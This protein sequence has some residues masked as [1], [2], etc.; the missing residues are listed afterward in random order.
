MTT[1]KELTSTPQTRLEALE[2]P[3]E[4]KVAR[5]DLDADHA[6]VLC[7]DFL[8]N[9]QDKP[10]GQIGCYLIDGKNI[11]S[12]LG[13][14]VETTVLHEY[15]SN[16]PELM[17]REYGPYDNASSFLVNINHE[18]EMPIG[19]MRIIEPSKVGLKSLNDLIRTPLRLSAEAVCAAYGMDQAKCLDVSTIAV[20][21]EYRGERGDN[22]A[23]LLMYRGLYAHFL[24]DPRY[25]HAVTIMDVKAKKS[26]DKYK[27]PF[28]PILDTE[29]F[30]YLDSPLSL[31]LIA[32]TSEFYPQVNY[33][34]QR[35]ERE[36]KEGDDSD[37]KGL[38]AGVMK[39]LKDGDFVDK[40]LGS[41]ITIHQSQD[42]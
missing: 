30:S 41:E 11:F 7:R 28:R 35:F 38:R 39:M 6:A 31:A 16:S 24:A 37:E 8:K 18:T 36:V 3:N 17:A 33:W 32:Q 10:D 15:F 40:L 26:I 22:L 23:S 29:P 25:T 34:Q 1:N 2:L 9:R 4:S 27:V 19:D 14:F 13:R 20:I 42:T 21:K 5:Y 12:N